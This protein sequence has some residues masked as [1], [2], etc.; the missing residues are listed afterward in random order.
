MTRPNPDDVR[1]MSGALLEARRTRVPIAPLTDRFPGMTAEDAYA[2]QQGLVAGL[3]AEG[4]SIIGYKLGLTSKPMQEM[5]GV[6]QPDYAPVLGSTVYSDGG[7]VPADRYIA[8]RMEAEICVVLDAPLSGPYC[9]AAEA[10]AATRGLVAALEIVDSRIADW[11]IALPDTI[12]DLASNGAVAFGSRVVPL[13]DF[14][15]ALIGM[16][17]T[18]NGDLVATGAGAAALGGPID[19]VAWLANTLH[20]LGV[21]LPAGA[22]IMTG[23]LHAAVP[24]QRGDVFRADFDR[25]GPINL[26]IT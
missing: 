21:T 9:S 17:F 16:V 11:K 14:D 4:D 6:D 24:F 10:W 20:P 2:V 18:R 26:R 22:I 1:E 25:L 15:P 7:D 23:A 13:G 3:L 12:A 8:P 19:A 5:L